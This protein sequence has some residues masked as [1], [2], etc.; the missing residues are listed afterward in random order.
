V[1]DFLFAIGQFLCVIGLLYG[2]ILSVV[3]WEYSDP[4]ER[5]HDPVTGHEGSPETADAIFELSIVPTR[6]VA[7]IETVRLIKG[8]APHSPQAPGQRPS[9]SPISVSQSE[10][11]ASCSRNP[12]FAAHTPTRWRLTA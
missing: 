6:S 4:I 12:C 2:M 8:G 3:N 9:A 7:M 1:L 5:R 10:A 11:A